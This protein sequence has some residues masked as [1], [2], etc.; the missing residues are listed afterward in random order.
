MSARRALFGL[1]ASL[2]IVSALL[3]STR[4]ARAYDATIFKGP[5]V[6][7]G[8]SAYDVPWNVWAGRTEGGFA[9]FFDLDPPAY[10]DVGYYTGLGRPVGRDFAFAALEGEDLSRFPE[11]SVSGIARRKVAEIEVAFRDGTSVREPVIKPRPFAL[12]KEPWLKRFRVF[13]IFFHETKNPAAVTAF[14]NIG[15]QVARAKSKRGIFTGL[16]EP[17]QP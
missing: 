11:G 4:D 17:D 9:F 7:K 13:D 6:A 12:T 14:N 2:A 15:E 16:F 10:P 5:L 1:L 3:A 8:E